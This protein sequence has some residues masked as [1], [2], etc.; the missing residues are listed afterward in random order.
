[1]TALPTTL[2][3]ADP[4]PDEAVRLSGL[5]PFSGSRLRR[6]TGR[7]VAGITV[8]AILVTMLAVACGR[9]PMLTT[10]F[11]DFLHHRLGDPDREAMGVTRPR[12]RAPEP[13]DPSR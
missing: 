5:I 8:E 12:P 3:L 9:Q 11:C 13:S 2:R 7:P 10:E 4:F 1:M 6:R